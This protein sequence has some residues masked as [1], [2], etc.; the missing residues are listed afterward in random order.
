MGEF[1]FQTV[2]QILHKP[3]SDNTSIKKEELYRDIFQGVYQA[4]GL[5][6]D[7]RKE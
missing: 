5:L 6:Q 3:L 2:F 4:P 1:N 7:R